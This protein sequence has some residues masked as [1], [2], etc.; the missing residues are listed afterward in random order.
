MA[1]TA[2]YY[3][4]NPEARAKR[5]KQQKRYNKTKKGLAL[6][7]NANRLNRQLGTYG[8]GDN[9]DAAHYKGVLPREDSKNHLPTEKA[10]SKY[11]ND[12]STT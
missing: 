4:S 3:R 6:R 2:K 1:G 9:K 11:V 12:P 5:L 7:V 8:N 10:D